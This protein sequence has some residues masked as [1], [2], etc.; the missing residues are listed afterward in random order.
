M[1]EF[2]QHGG[3]LIA[4]G[5]LI[6]PI[7]PGYKRPLVNQWQDWR[8]SPDEYQ[9]I[10]SNGYPYTKKDKTETTIYPRKH[11]LGVVCGIGE[12]SVAAIDIDTTNSKLAEKFT[13]WC[14]ARLG[15]GAE[16]VGNAPKILLVYQ[17]DQ[18]G[19]TKQASSWF[20]DADDNRHRLEILGKGQQFVAYATH[21]DTGQPYQWVDLFGGLLELPASELPVITAE[22][23]AEAIQTFEHMAK[24]AGLTQFKS[25]NQPAAPAPRPADSVAAAL[26]EEPPLGWDD[27]RINEMLAWCYPD[28]YDEWLKVGMALHHERPDD[29]GLALWDTWSKQSSKYAGVDDLTH[30]WSGFGQGGHR[31]ITLRTLIIW[32]KER[33]QDTLKQQKRSQR[34]ETRQR[35]EACQDTLDLL[36]DVAREAGK[37]AGSDAV[38]R[39]EFAGLLQKRFK[40]LAGA[41]MPIG[42]VREAM[43]GTKRVPAAAESQR[44]HWSRSCPTWARGWVYVAE[45]NQFYHLE[46]RTQVEPAGFRGLF[47]CELPPGDD[48]PNAA[49][50]VLNGQ[51]I[52]K[53]DRL[54]Y[55]PGAEPLFDVDGVRL[56]NTYSK[57]GMVEIPD[58]LDETSEAA[59]AVFRRHLELFVGGGQWTREVQILVNWLRWQLEHIDQPT[60]WAILMQ[61]VFGDGKSTVFGDLFARLFGTGNTRVVQ[62][63]TIESSR[64]NAWAKD[65][66][67]ILVEEIKLH[68]HNRYDV[69]NT[70][71]PLITNN[72]IEVHPK[73]KDPINVPNFAVYFI[74]TNY[75]DGVPLEQNDRRYFVIFSRFPLARIKQQ[76]PNYFDDLFDAVRE[77]AG[78]V[79]RWILDTPYHDDF[80]PY[81]AP[82][83]ADKAEATALTSDEFKDV[84]ADI[85][86][87]SA[88]PA[89][90]P[91]V[92]LYQP[93]FDYL[94]LQNRGETLNITPY[95]L[96]KALMDLG[97]T[98]L[99]R[100]RL[101]DGDRYR[102]WARCPEGDPDVDWVKQVVE[103]RAVNNLI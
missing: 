24:G 30:R 66:R 67:M 84:V 86:A 36:H 57:N 91:E 68:G 7:Q 42:Q 101:L 3:Q 20:K 8:L 29:T 33:E 37:A 96:N 26:L 38:L 102:V 100:H 12:H 63:A 17:A 47:D 88:S 55:M 75:K 35:I 95:Q 32:A 44:M 70:L 61:G 51:H 72:V 99:G 4:N 93:F 2:Q 60:K 56:A 48:I 27:A 45:V 92:V 103:T 13:R 77:H 73:G 43:R 59:A 11:G 98:K 54:M 25:V 74:T 85:L 49:Q 53:V 14:E 16:R 31:P 89:F 69:T 50:L 5:Y 97:F 87:D 15:M 80:E 22:Q 90:G 41:N 81:N 94:T 10:L 9:N 65:R 82:W 40:Q 28:E 21:P 18:E 83:T 64:F 23:V 19:W 58:V 62:G 78:A 79:G 76:E 39:A 46:R 1:G 6:V 34:D 71:K 52:P